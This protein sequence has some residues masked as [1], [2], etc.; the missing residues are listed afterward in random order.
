M[1][2]VIKR[3][4]QLPEIVETT[5]GLADLCR[6]IGGDP[7]TCLSD[8]EGRERVVAY[9]DVDYLVK[10]ELPPLN[11][12]RPADGHPI[13]GTVV[14]VGTE[15]SPIGE[16]HDASLSDEQANMWMWLLAWLHYEAL[17]TLSAAGIPWPDELSATAER[18]EHQLKSMREAALRPLFAKL[19]PDSRTRAAMTMLSVQLST[20]TYEPPSSIVI[21]CGGSTVDPDAPTLRIPH[22][23]P[24]YTSRPRKDP[25]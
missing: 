21:A 19:T 3:P 22:H 8:G 11:F 24:M 16:P 12:F 1:R 25:P 6:I 23:D 2:V 18:D 14:A 10:E 13:H 15:L 20:T 9:C 4:M 5:G 7:E 17:A